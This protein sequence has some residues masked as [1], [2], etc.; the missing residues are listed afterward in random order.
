MTN[1]PQALPERTGNR[2]PSS[3]TEPP[4][5]NKLTETEAVAG[6]FPSTC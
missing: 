1:W 3:S 4:D 6:L 5:H 2:C